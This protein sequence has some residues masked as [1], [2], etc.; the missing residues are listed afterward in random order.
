MSAFVNEMD[1]RNNLSKNIKY[2]MFR[3][4]IKTQQEFA[5]KM[6]I[7]PATLVKILNKSQMPTLYPF[8]SNLTELSGYSVEELVNMDLSQLEKGEFDDGENQLDENQKNKLCGLYILHYFDT[9]AFKGREDK[10]AREALVFGLLLIYKDKNGRHCSLALFGLKQ[11]EMLN[12]FKSWGG[13]TTQNISMATVA[14]KMREYLSVHVYE[15]IVDISNGHIYLNLNYGNRDHAYVILHRPDGTAKH[16]IGG[17]GAMVSVSKGRYSSPCQQILGVSRYYLDVSEEEIARR[18][19]LGYPSIKPGDKC[20]PLIKLIKQMY[21]PEPETTMFTDR[22]HFDMDLTD[23]HKEYIIRGEIT[24]IITDMV[25]NNMYRTSKIS[26]IDDDEWYHF[27]KKFDP[28]K[29]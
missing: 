8:F 10:S 16:Y 12:R 7:A 26:Y 15:G 23:V 24:K 6:G 25:E 28:K 2:V 13:G 22:S 21:Q 1:G 18:L 29:R 19:Q 9:S 20:E 11:E 27:V 4:G 14:A 3:K 17:L 5:D